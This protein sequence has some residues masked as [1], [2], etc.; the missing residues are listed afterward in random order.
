MSNGSETDFVQGMDFRDTAW[1]KTWWEF[2]CVPGSKLGSAL[3]YNTSSFNSNWGQNSWQRI[4][5]QLYSKQHPGAGPVVSW[6]DYTRS[7]TAYNATSVTNFDITPG[8]QMD[9]PSIYML[10][11]TNTTANL[12]GIDSVT[13]NGIVG[14]YL[15]WKGSLGM[16]SIKTRA[17][18]HSVNGTLSTDSYLPYSDI[19]LRVTSLNWVYFFLDTNQ[20]LHAADWADLDRATGFHL[21]YPQYAIASAPPTATESRTMYLYYQF[22][23]TTLAEA[24]FHDGVWDEDIVFIN[25]S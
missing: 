17:F 7:F 8:P 19:L 23:G 25:V 24:S 5:F 20:T 10:T 1:Q 14:D 22:N 4:F 2:P 21:T 18:T 13:G 3:P 16:S 9:P 12:Y 15:G 11:P 6:S